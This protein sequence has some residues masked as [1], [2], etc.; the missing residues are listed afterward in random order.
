VLAGLAASALGLAPRGP[1]AQN[2]GG[3]LVVGAGMAGL[4]AARALQDAGHGVTVLEARARIGGR[5]HT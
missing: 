1:G 4:A 3:T 5:L 2:S